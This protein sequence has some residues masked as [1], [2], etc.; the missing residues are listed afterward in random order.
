MTN[1][2]LV[3]TMIY[4][5]RRSLNLAPILAKKSCFLMGP[6]QTGKTTLIEQQF[7]KI[8]IIQ[9]LDSETR[10]FLLQNPSRLS[11]M[12]PENQKI[13][14]IDE[15]QKIPELLDQ[16]HLLIEKRKINFLL[17][18]SSSRKLKRTGVNLLGGRARKRNLFP[19]TTDE[20]KEKF[21]LQKALEIGTLPSIYFSDSPK[22]DL[23]VYASEYL[24]QEIAA[25]GITR[26]IP[27][28]ARFLEVAA[29]SN[30]QM[31]NY[32]A[33]S[34]DAGVAR[35]TVQHHYEILEDTLIG[36]R[37]KA[38][39]KTKTRKSIGKEKFYFFDTGVVNSLVGRKTLSLKTPE[40]GFL[41]ETFL[42]NEVH[43][44]SEYFA[45]DA[46]FSYWQSKSG[47]E[48]D[49]FLNE[50]IAVEIKAK[51]SVSE[52]DLKSLLALA[53]EKKMKRM[54]CVYLGKF[55][56]KIGAVEIIPYDQFL[57]E[58]WDGEVF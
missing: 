58:L 20:L 21:N 57:A 13:A 40:S 25:E 32:T 1:A 24:T 34:S 2:H 29:L 4:M 56:Q 17:T 53:E 55:T 49:L 22:E 31:I 45:K 26:N 36:Y 19:L 10:S 43:A 5:Q 12:I 7:P 48:V 14:V 18:G 11:G 3:G 54:I 35:T 47:F 50:E 39:T 38:W 28:F 15:I 16:V 51:E 42:L 23:S 41:F 46:D 37:L 8:Q 30:A 27:S 6:R 33:V 9:L 44:Y 52:R